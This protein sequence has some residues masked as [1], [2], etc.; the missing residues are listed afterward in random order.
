MATKQVTAKKKVTTPAKRDPNT[1][2]VM[3]F[4]G[5][6][7]V[8]ALAETSLSTITINA[9]TARSFSKV[10]G[11]TD[12]SETIN[13]MRDKVVKVNGGDL[14]ELEA[15]LTAQ[16]VTLDT[17]FNELARRASLNMGEHLSAA[18]TYMRLALK[19]Q[20]QCSR[21]IETL[22]A[23][24]NPPVIFAKQMNVANGNQLV[25]NASSP[26]ATHTEKTI[27]QSNELLTKGNHATLDTSRTTT[28]SGI[29]QNMATVETLDRGKDD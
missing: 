26:N 1:L 22:A 11:I 3:V 14:T 15:T 10:V 4:K 16:T 24:K 20:S 28:A 8:R 25:H 9:A 29:N 17:M 13:V 19:A 6:N 27:N 7:E 12:L 21:T 2:Q 5:E 18:E 23:M